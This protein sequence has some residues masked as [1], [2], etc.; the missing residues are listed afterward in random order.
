MA[1]STPTKTPDKPTSN[2]GIDQEK[3]PDRHQRPDKK[4]QNPQLPTRIGNGIK[5][6]ATVKCHQ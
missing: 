6:P 1:P 4:D 3:S 2:T 5:V